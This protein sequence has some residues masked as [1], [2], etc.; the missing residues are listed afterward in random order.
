M[1]YISDGVYFVDLERKITYWNEAA[2]KITG[3]SANEVMN[4]A[5]FDD[6]L[7]H[8]TED[9]THLC[10]GSCPFKISME[11]GNVLNNQIYFLHKEGYRVPVWIKV[12]PLKDGTGKIVGAFQVFNREVE[13]QAVSTELIELRQ[14]VQT[15]ILTGVRSRGYLESRL[16]TILLET[17]ILQNLFALLFVDIDHFKTI[18]DEY[19]HV[20]GDRVLRMVANTLMENTRE[21]DIVG[22]W[23]G[24]EFL[25]ILKSPGSRE[26]VQSI[27]EKLRILLENSILTSKL[28]KVN[29]S[30]SIGV[31]FPTVDDS[32]EVIIERADQ[33]MYQSKHAGRNRI[34]LQN[35]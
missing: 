20:E 25:V 10:G 31:A 4:R 35:E 22:R 32:V 2:S 15:D 21:A 17:K 33:L 28:D 24:D 26:M 8:I 16:D 5:C 18:N 27:A 3:Y 12:V 11:N 34:T 7:N 1:N 9:G 6:R 30:V 13:K 19:G 23:G 14:K 29:I